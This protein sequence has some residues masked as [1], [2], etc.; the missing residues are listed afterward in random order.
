MSRSVRYPALSGAAFT[1]LMV[2][3]AALFPMPAGGDVSPAAD[4][5]WLTAHSSAVIAQSG[6]RALAALAFIA[7]SAVLATAC[8]Q[9]ASRASTLP[10]LALVGGSLS[11]VLL[12]AG[13]GISLAAALYAR[14]GGE[15]AT[16]RAL[17]S[18]QEGLLDA[19]ALPALLLFLAVGL[20]ALRTGLLPRWLGVVSLV[21]VPVALVDSASYD[22][23]PF[24]AVGLIG[25]GYFLAWSLL[26]S[27]RLAVSSPSAALQGSEPQPA[28]VA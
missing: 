19:S 6:V 3:G 16:T 1:V 9:A 12:L 24:E 5:S 17:G 28:G 8:R 23:G 18:L 21:G 15:P 22:G 25:L 20:T 10:A 14:D 13:Q 2:L 26:T 4:P 27:V 7:F 11:G